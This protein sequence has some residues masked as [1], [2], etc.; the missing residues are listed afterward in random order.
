LELAKNS[1]TEKGMDKTGELK[2][3]SFLKTYPNRKKL[4]K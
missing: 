2:Y 4:R 1:D 3:N